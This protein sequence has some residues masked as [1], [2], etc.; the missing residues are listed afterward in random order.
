MG[1]ERGLS[2]HCLLHDDDP[3]PTKKTGP[4][5]PPFLAQTSKQ[6]KK[7]TGNERVRRSGDEEEPPFFLLCILFSSS[8]SGHDH[9]AA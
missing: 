5:L 9:L 4:A 6:E 3:S 8:S 2:I 1:R 7:Q